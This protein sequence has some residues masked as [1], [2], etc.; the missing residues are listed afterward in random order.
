MSTNSLSSV[1]QKPTEYTS[2]VSTSASQAGQR[3]DSSGEGVRVEISASSTVQYKKPETQP[4][5]TIEDGVQAEEVLRATISE[6][7]RNPTAAVMAQANQDPQQL[8][9]FLG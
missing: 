3:Q 1:S 4:A 2:Q 5:F 6:M 8:V 9:A 7:L